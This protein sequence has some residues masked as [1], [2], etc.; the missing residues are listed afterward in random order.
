MSRSPSPGLKRA[1]RTYG[2][3][4]TVL[5]TT[6]P[7]TPQLPVSS[8]FGDLPP[9]SDDRDASNASPLREDGSDGEGGG[10][11]TTAHNQ[12][13]PSPTFAG[14]KEVTASDGLSGRLPASPHESPPTVAVRQHAEASRPA[15]PSDDIS[16]TSSPHHPI[17]TPKT[18]S[19]SSPPTSAEAPPAKGK[20]PARSAMQIHSSSEDDA[21]SEAKPT[22]KTRRAKAGGNKEAAKRTKAL[23]KKEQLEMHKASARMTAEQTTAIPRRQ[24][25]KYSVSQLGHRFIP[26]KA[27]AS[28]F[29]EHTRS[30]HLPTSDPIQPFSSPTNTL[31]ALMDLPVPASPTT[32]PPPQARLSQ[33]QAEKLYQDP[34]H[35]LSASDDDDDLPDAKDIVEAQL[36]AKD[37][38][39][40]KM[41]WVQRQRQQT[42]PSDEGDDDDLLI[43]DEPRSAIRDAAQARRHELALGLSPSKGRKQQL[44]Q[45]GPSAR[46]G[47]IAGGDEKRVLAMLATSTFKS[48]SLPLETKNM[49]HRQLNEF[50]AKMIEKDKVQ[51]RRRKEEDHIRRG[52]RLKEHAEGSTIKNASEPVQALEQI[53]QRAAKK[54]REVRVIEDSD[55]QSDGDYQPDTLATDDDEGGAGE[56]DP[57]RADTNEEADDEEDDDE[58]PFLPP[59]H[60]RRTRVPAA[61]VV[62]SDDE[63]S[64]NR[65]VPPTAGSRARNDFV[66]SNAFDLIPTEPTTSG[67]TAPR[68]SV[69]SAGEH[70]D[71][72]HTED[73]TDKENDARLSFDRGDDKENTRIAVQRSLSRPRLGRGA[74][75]FAAEIEASPSGR[76]TPSSVRSPLKAIPTGDD[77]VFGPFLAPTAANAVGSLQ[78]SPMNL[79]ADLGGGLGGG[80][81]GGGGFSQFLTQD[82]N[83]RGFDQLKAAPGH[84]DLELT[85]DDSLQ[86]ALDVSSSLKR[87]VEDAF[88]KEQEQLPH[89]DSARGHEPVT[90]EDPVAICQGHEVLLPGSILASSVKRAPLG[91]LMSQIPDEDEDEERPRRLRKR[92]HSTSPVRGRLSPP[93][94]KNA[95][96]V[97]GKPPTKGKKPLRSRKDEDDD[98]DDEELDQIDKALVD[99]RHMTVDEVNEDGELDDQANERL[100]RDAAEGKL[101]TKRRDRGVGFDSSDS[102]YENDGGP[103]RAK[104]RGKTT[105]ALPPSEDA[106][107]GEKDGGQQSNTVTVAELDQELREVANNSKEFEEFDPNDLS[108]LEE[109][110]VE[111]DGAREMSQEEIER[112]RLA[113]QRS[114]HTD[115]MAKWASRET[116]SR[117]AGVVGRNT[118]G[119]AAVTGHAKSK[120]SG[121]GSFKSASS[122]S[123]SAGP[124]RGMKIGKAPSMLTATTTSRRAKF[125]STDRP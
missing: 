108:Y 89:P 101:R 84:D 93:K 117:T 11:F 54:R 60:H 16:P 106:E 25:N 80:F 36:R 12:R 27:P 114:S 73:G 3:P 53:R 31:S 72:A 1:K 107:S 122:A 109:N 47:L 30:P 9:D 55:D 41:G 28:A 120:A 82:E 18:H 95:F 61:R 63:E 112:Q 20:R 87:R 92:D 77:D 74:S 68:G 78:G 98:D 91:T 33:T 103:R 65:P 116:S 67:N 42:P 52:G 51:E 56:N 14:P 40:L 17:N 58:N 88:L 121:G 46:K 115:N 71:G 24:Q 35:H 83:A 7:S 59:R 111:D 99:D 49:T 125:K 2:R 105:T 26:P 29:K 76:G 23:S 50:L 34:G 6:A 86:P 48:G 44:K 119:S 70:T 21:P 97:L 15:I 57:P 39:N 104:K 90:H 37:L 79:D 118:G 110:D 13:V 123:A 64:E 69:S 85:Q 113:T 102:E 45:A 4:G 5:D 32:P 43:E 124:K 10:G 8:A 75:L 19:S 62:G 38:H 100:A 94:F 66:L 96:D 22:Y 81:G